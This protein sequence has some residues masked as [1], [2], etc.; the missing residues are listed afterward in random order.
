MI[1]FLHGNKYTQ[2]IK[3]KENKLLKK[4]TKMIA[5]FPYSD[6]EML[7]N[8]LVN[9]MLKIC[10]NPEGTQP[11]RYPNYKNGHPMG[12]PIHYDGPNTMYYLCWYV[13]E[14]L[15]H[16]HYISHDFSSFITNIAENENP[17][18]PGK[19]D[20]TNYFV[21]ML[22]DSRTVYN[23]HIYVYFQAMWDS[24]DG[25][26]EKWNTN[27]AELR[28]A[29]NS[30]IQKRMTDYQTMTK[31]KVHSVFGKWK[32]KLESIYGDQ[33]GSYLWQ[34]TDFDELGQ[35]ITEYNTYFKK[36]EDAKTMVCRLR[37]PE[38]K[39]HFA[40]QR[41]E[42][43]VK[44]DEDNNIVIWAVGVTHN[45][46]T[47]VYPA[48]P[49]SWMT[50]SRAVMP[51]VSMMGHTSIFPNDPTSWMDECKSKDIKVKFVVLEGDLT[52]TNYE[53]YTL[54]E[55]PQNI[56]LTKNKSQTMLITSPPRPVCGK[57]ESLNDFA[58]RFLAEC[59]RKAAEQCYLVK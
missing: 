53:N 22:S 20:F 21:S 17:E 40:T 36:N 48:T 13:W 38:T 1:F 37:L 32:T 23:T 34:C 55:N 35:F 59:E 18:G 44:I 41:N 8:K 43:L 15:G 56:V 54:M 4:K 3:N 52:S 49:D 58:D 31:G 57:N 27:L 51:M 42:Q 6:S 28:K 33:W 24:C 25:S 2:P 26:E 14:F 46:K 47:Y 9:N 5:R 30:Y 19:N 39:Q 45:N 50:G 12:R 11:V 7:S 16:L 10:P 29:F